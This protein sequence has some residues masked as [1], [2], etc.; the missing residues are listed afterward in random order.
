[1]GGAALRGADTPEAHHVL[2]KAYQERGRPDSALPELRLASE[3]APAQEVF[4]SDF[5]QALLDHGDFAEALALLEKGQRQFPKSPQIALAYWCGLLCPSA[6]PRC[7]ERFPRSD[8]PGPY[9]GAAYVFLGRIRSTRA[10]G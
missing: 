10:A 6:G 8:P 5:A 4:L 3:R 2:G 9:G 1:V 7:R